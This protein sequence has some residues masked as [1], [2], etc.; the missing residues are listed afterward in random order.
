[1]TLTD[2]QSALDLGPPARHRES[3]SRLVRLLRANPLGAFGAAVIALLL[4][5]GILAPA[6]A[7]YRVDSFAGVPS[8]GPSRAHPFG[9]DK[10][11]QDIL[12]RVLTGA[13][14]SLQ[15]GLVAVTLGTLAGMAIGI[16]SGYK[17][18]AV[19]TLI[20]RVVDTAIAFPQIILLLIIV[21]LLGPSLRNVVIVV[22]IGIIPSVSR[23][24]RAAVL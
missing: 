12:S 2:G 7:P 4:L 11:G 19:D 24:L 13:R 10:F 15:V 9:T 6:I 18:G 3:R 23:V 21:R 20:M 22:A 16:V 14:I 8:A 5:A 1:M 17:G